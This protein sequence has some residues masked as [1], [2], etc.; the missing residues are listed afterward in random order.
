MPSGVGR[1][2]GVGQSVEERVCRINSG[3][4]GLGGF[5][6]GVV[7]VGGLGG[8]GRMLWGCVVPFFVLAIVFEELSRCVV[9]AIRCLSLFLYLM[10]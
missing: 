8:Q 7:A 3:L 6:F 2:G 4:V 9:V 5:C 1:A 10:K